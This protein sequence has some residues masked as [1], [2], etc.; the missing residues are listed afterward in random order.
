[1]TK[2]DCNDHPL[3]ISLVQFTSVQFILFI[4]SRRGL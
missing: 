3:F 4:W 1:V 2:T